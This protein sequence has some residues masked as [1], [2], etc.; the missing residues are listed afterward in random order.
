M[1]KHRSPEERIKE[2][3]E[4]AKLEISENGYANLT[5]DA[6]ASRA[7]LSKG[8]IYRFYSN[9]RDIALALFDGIY[10]EYAK[11]DYDEIIKLNLSPWESLFTAIMTAHLRDESYLTNQN[12]WLQILPETVN[13]EEF[14]KIKKE[15]LDNIEK[16]TIEA[17]RIILKKSG[18]QLL[19]EGELDIQRAF[20]TS[21][22]LLEG[23]IIEELSGTPLEDLAEQVKWYLE[24]II[25]KNIE[26]I[27]GD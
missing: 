17:L 8:S 22:M 26:N 10:S 15:H 14:R 21:N 2:I 1:T 20:Y 12:I 13:D 24:T 9:K 18:M 3:L 4:A 27:P 23:M 16:R 25:K 7:G 11:I 6:I 5:I 19:P